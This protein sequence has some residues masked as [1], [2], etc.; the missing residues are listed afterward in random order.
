MP[1]V[2]RKQKG[3]LAELMV[4]CDLRR[5]GCKIAIPFGE[6]S[7]YD[8]VIDRGGKLERV[9]VKHADSRGEVISVQCYSNS[10]T[11]GRARSVKRYTAAMI[12]WLAV[13]DRA[14]DRSYYIPAR[15]LGSG[16]R[17]LRPRITPPRN[18]QRAGI[19]YAQDY[20]DLDEYPQ[21]RLNMEPAGLEPAPSCL[22]G[23]R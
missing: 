7:D 21:S 2:T 20:L 11:N 3:D 18:N 16:R 14:T 13:Y 8:L 4:A 9:Q 10:L 5:R 12:D 17:E 23:M 22:Q 6:E 1:E 19:R 15:E